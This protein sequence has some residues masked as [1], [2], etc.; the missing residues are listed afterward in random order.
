MKKSRLATILMT[1][2]AILVL[3]TTGSNA[4]AAGRAYFDQGAL[5]YWINGSGRTATLE[6]ARGSYFGNICGTRIDFTERTSSQ[7]LVKRSVGTTVTGCVS[8]TWRE[9]Y[10]VTYAS[11]TALACASLY[12][13]GALRVSHCHGIE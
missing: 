11:N 1:T 8:Q 4:S 3:T 12:I 7:A 9:R 13:N 10:N 2:V 5:D 6:Q